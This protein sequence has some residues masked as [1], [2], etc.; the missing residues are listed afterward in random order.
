MS[1]DEDI[2]ALVVDNGSGMCKGM[3]WFFSLYACFCLYSPYHQPHRQRW[4]MTYRLISCRSKLLIG[5]IAILLWYT[6]V[7]HTT[8]ACLPIVSN[9]HGVALPASRWMLSNN[10]LTLISAVG[11]HNTFTTCLCCRR[12]PSDKTKCGSDSSSW[13]PQLSFQHIRWMCFSLLLLMNR[14]RERSARRVILSRMFLLK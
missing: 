11:V 14:R 9:Y 1:D 3:F 7:I 13:A 2:A 8:C 10:I 12:A 4:L 5:M 6:I